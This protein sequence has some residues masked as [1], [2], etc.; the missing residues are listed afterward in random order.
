M[1]NSR[2]GFLVEDDDE[3]LSELAIIEK[4]R[5]EERNR[6]ENEGAWEPGKPADASCSSIWVSSS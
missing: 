5:R 4:K 2:G 6:A 3:G 1:V